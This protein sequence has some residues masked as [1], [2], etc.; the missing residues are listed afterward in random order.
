MIRGS[1]SRHSGTLLIENWKPLGAYIGTMPRALRWP[2][3]GG[4]VCCERG[5]PV[6]ERDVSLAGVECEEDEHRLRG[7][8][9]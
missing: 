7:C 1:L 9:A 5:T 6:R 3:G 4:A 2:Q 8:G